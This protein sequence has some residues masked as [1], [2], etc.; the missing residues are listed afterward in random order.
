VGIAVEDN[1]RGV[2]DEVLP[3]LFER[4]YRGDSARGRNAGAGLGLTVAAAIVRAHGGDIHA[5]RAG[6][7]GLRV[8]ISLPRSAEDGGV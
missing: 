4:F 1:G 6:E 3:H 2:A 5:E 8:S 7:S